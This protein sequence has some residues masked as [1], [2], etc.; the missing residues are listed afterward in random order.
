MSKNLARR[1]VTA[2][3]LLF[4]ASSHAAALEISRPALARGQWPVLLAQDET[5]KPASRH[6][7]K[8]PP[9]SVKCSKGGTPTK[10]TIV[11]YGSPQCANTDR[12]YRKVILPLMTQHPDKVGLLMGQFPI[13]EAFPDS[14]EAARLMLA[15]RAHGKFC[16]MLKAEFEL[17]ESVG[18][19][20]VLTPE[21]KQELAKKIGLDPATLEAEASSEAVKQMLQA[22]R[23]YAK[24]I[25]VKASPTIFVNGRLLEQFSEDA[26]RRMVQE[27]L[28]K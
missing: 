10:V 9:G 1:W 27:E 24:E 23:D 19:R 17:F 6:E 28:N 13:A 15:A 5:P 25:G 8:A 3:A 22:D 12:F 2:V 4:I 26:L 20:H 11:F 14:E 21:R 7:L 18:A 16:P